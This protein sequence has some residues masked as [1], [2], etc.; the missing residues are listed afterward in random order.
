M[1]LQLNLMY[2]IYRPIALGF[3]LNEKKF[4]FRKN[5]EQ[6][7]ANKS[8]LLFNYLANQE[9]GLTVKLKTFVSH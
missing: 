6:P 2:L 9:Q 7:K 8:F 4:I 1:I 5:L 3:L